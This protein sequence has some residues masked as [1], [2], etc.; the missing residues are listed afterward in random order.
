MRKH[1]NALKLN[2]ILKTKYIYG[3]IDL[4]QSILS[5]IIHVKQ[6]NSR[7]DYII[8]FFPLSF[9]RI[10]VYKNIK[11]LTIEIKH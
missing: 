5:L 3:H 4:N 1:A 7:F 9:S 2:Y 8:F 11:S 6:S 10:I